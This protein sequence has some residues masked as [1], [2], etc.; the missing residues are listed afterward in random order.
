MDGATVYGLTDTDRAL[1]A[2]FMAGVNSTA[3]LKFD[4]PGLGTTATH[5]GDRLVIQNDIGTTDAHVLVL[6]VV[7]LTLT[8]MYTDI[9]R[10]APPLFSESPGADGLPVDRPAV[11]A[12][13]T[14]V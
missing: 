1:V 7:G 5:A 3:P 2:A 6:H 10:G 12:D 8:V 13:G 11:G 14:G 4:H 9:H